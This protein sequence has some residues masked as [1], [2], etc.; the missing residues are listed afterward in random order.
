MPPKNDAT[1]ATNENK[2]TVV[3]DDKMRVALANDKMVQ[4]RQA[5]VAGYILV[6]AIAQP[7][8]VDRLQATGDLVLIESLGR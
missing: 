4:V 1:A 8:L 2:E 5:K 6:T 7:N 3:V